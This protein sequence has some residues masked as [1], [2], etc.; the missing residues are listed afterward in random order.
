VQAFRIGWRVYATQFHPELDLVGLYTR[1][2][3][4]KHA[5]YFEPE[6]ADEL[7]AKASRSNVTHPPAILRQFVHRYTRDPC[8]LR[9][10]H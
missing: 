1:I 5:G 3:V 8:G 10:P 6:Q 2:E 4:Y 7:K 9:K